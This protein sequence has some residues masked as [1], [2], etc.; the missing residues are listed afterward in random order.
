[1]LFQLGIAVPAIFFVNMFSN[2]VVYERIE[3]DLTAKAFI[4]E[5]RQALPTEKYEVI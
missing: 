3:G 1:M 2:E 5:R 4:E